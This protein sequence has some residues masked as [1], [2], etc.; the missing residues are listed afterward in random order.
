VD[1]SGKKSSINPQSNRSLENAI[2]HLWQWYIENPPN[3]RMQHDR[4]AREIVAILAL[5]YA[6]R[7]RRLMRIP[8]AGTMTMLQCT[9]TIVTRVIV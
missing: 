8:L 7:S 2:D 4:F 3:T 1:R 5:S 9:I 6:A